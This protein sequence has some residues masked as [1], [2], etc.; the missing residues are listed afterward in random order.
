MSR[1]LAGIT[2]EYISLFPD[3]AVK[4]IEAMAPEASQSLMV[5]LSASECAKLFEHTTLT[6]SQRWIASLPLEK[7]TAI[8]QLMAND[9]SALL[10]RRMPKDLK[11]QV[12]QALPEFKQAALSQTL[13]YPSY[14]IGSISDPIVLSIADDIPIQSALDQ[15]RDAQAYEH[16]FV[17]VVNRSQQFVGILSLR[18]FIVAKPDQLVRAV[19]KRPKLL[20]SAMNSKKA[21][22]EAISAATEDEIP[23]ID[24]QKRLVGVL[25]KSILARLEDSAEDIADNKPQSILLSFAELFW[26]I[27]AGFLPSTRKSTD[28]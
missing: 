9:I 2:Q 25:R 26:Q 6:Q 28:P 7:A 12:M 3:E 27:T 18:E 19:M 21:F 22:S 15:I 14:T 10:I 1:L 4:F 16:Q 20:L 8:L 5:S 13:D 11:A 23:V 17:Y 24:E